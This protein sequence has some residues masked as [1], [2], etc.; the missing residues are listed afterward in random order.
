MAPQTENVKCTTSST[1]SA[2]I[3]IKC[4]KA[5]IGQYKSGRF[6]IDYGNGRSLDR[7]KLLRLEVGSSSVPFFV[8]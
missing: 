7:Q 1:Y 8:S 5:K 2:L 4:K 3:I 6:K